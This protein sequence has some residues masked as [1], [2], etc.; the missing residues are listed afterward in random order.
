[1][2]DHTDVRPELHELAARQVDGAVLRY[3]PGTAGADAVEPMSERVEDAVERLAGFG[4]QGSGVLP[5]ICLVDPFPHP[6]TDEV[7]AEG[8]VV[9]AERGEIW[10][11]VTPEDPPEP[12]ERALALLYGAALPAVAELVPLI[13]G[14]GL[15]LAGR[16]DPDERLREVELPP[17][18]RAEGDLLAAM[19]LSFVRYLLG[20]EDEEELRRFLAEAR[21]GAV[22]VTAREVYGRG[23]PRLEA[24]WRERLARGAPTMPAGEFLRSTLTYLR[25]HWRRQLEMGVYMLLGLAFSLIFPFIFRQNDKKPTGIFDAVSMGA[26]QY[27]IFLDALGRA[28]RIFNSITAATV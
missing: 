8:T 12:P 2:T 4:S 22:D 19:S 6:E 25:P 26:A 5:Q 9:D 16:P 20:Q 17:L 3:E 7:I 24:D 27:L 13:E 18:A 28:V 21:P 1:M 23:L 15:H 11:V 14:Y 10:M